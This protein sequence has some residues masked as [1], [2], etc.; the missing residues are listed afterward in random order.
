MSCV[1]ARL[2]LSLFS[3]VPLTS[4]APQPPHFITTTVAPQPSRDEPTV[5][6]V[7]RAEPD[8][9]LPLDRRAVLEIVQEFLGALELASSPR[10]PLLDPEARVLATTTGRSRSL[11]QELSEFLEAQTNVTPQPRLRFARERFVTR[12]VPVQHSQGQRMRVSAP[13]RQDPLSKK[14]ASSEWIVIVHQTSRGLRIIEV[15]TP[16]G[17]LS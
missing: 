17:R 10:A 9:E 11:S 5:A 2:S 4:C 8:L 3:L 7:T 12:P 13:L 15:Q 16:D 6:R 14:N 1:R